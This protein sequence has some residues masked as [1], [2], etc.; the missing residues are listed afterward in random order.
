MQLSMR[1]VVWYNI[2]MSSEIFQ[3]ALSGFVTDVAVGDTVRALVRKGYSVSRIK[4]HLD[5][6]VSEEKL[7]QMVWNCLIDTGVILLTEPGTSDAKRGYTYERDRSPYG[8][9]T[10]RRVTSDSEETET[11]YL[12]CEFGSLRKKD[13][14]GFEISLQTLLP[15][16]RE[17]VLDL[18]WPVATVWHAEDERMKRIMSTIKKESNTR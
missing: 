4:K 10:Y 17:Y 18:P 15:E 5:Y 13:P 2:K 12:P 8:T 16:D 9:V 6:P 14:E 1:V 3:N 11:S 7:R